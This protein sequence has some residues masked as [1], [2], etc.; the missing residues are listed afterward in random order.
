MSKRKLAVSLTAS[1]AAVSTLLAPVTSAETTAADD[2][3]CV[4]QIDPRQSENISDSE[5]QLRKQ[6]NEKPWTVRTED[7]PTQVIAFITSVHGWKQQLE[8]FDRMRRKGDITDEVYFWETEPIA[9]LVKIYS[10]EAIPQLEKCAKEAGGENTETASLSTADG[11]PNNVG[12][13]LIASGATLA[14]VGL[15]AAIMPQLKNILPAQ[16]V[17]LLP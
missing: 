15:I 3:V 13:G 2:S 4:I 5:K 6:I 17:A 1:L 7:V 11:E 14:I 9:A 10:T 12:A 8:N 16:L